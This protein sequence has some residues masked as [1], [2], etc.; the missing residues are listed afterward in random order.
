M[1][2]NRLMKIVPGSVALLL[3]M[4]FFASATELETPPP[5]LFADVAMQGEALY[6]NNLEPFLGYR[7]QT[8]RFSARHVAIGAYGDVG[9][10]IHYNVA[11]GTATCLGSGAFTLLDAGVFYQLN[12]FSQIGYQKGEILRG[13]AFFDECTQVLAA[14]KPRFS[15]TFAP[16]HPTGASMWFDHKFENGFD[17]LGQLSV[18]NGQTTGKLDDEYDA[19]AGITLGLPVEGLAVTGFYNLLRNYYGNDA[20]TAAPIYDSGYRWGTGIEYR[21]Q[22]IWFRTEM[23][24]L[25]GAYGHTAFEDAAHTK[26]IA[27]E[28][29][30]MS[31]FYVEAGYAFQINNEYLKAIQPYAR[32]Q[33][34]DK[35]SNA[36]GDHTFSWLTGG[37]AFLLD[38]ETN[39]KLRFDY[40]APLATPEGHKRDADMFVIRLQTTVGEH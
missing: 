8:S 14:E 9:S 5:N 13:F 37:V 40:E 18:M 36:D 29:M 21:T 20:T 12:S 38:R 25:K 6:G 7:A 27:A 11:V 10:R 3:V 22:E 4:S 32:Y 26:M 35:A 16:C 30:E 39:T 33:S 2:K 23:Y 24:R 17:L 19:N 15:P 28:D 1:G 31:A 34:W